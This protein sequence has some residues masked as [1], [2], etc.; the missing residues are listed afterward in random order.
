MEWSTSK[1]FKWKLCLLLAMSH[2]KR[3][4]THLQTFEEGKSEET[5]ASNPKGTFLKELE[6]SQEKEQRLSTQCYALR[7]RRNR[8]SER[9]KDYELG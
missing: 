7:P 4:V 8:Q 3:N 2:Y 1:E 5:M 6:A 9:L